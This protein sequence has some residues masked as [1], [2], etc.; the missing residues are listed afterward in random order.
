VL[1]PFV[2]VVVAFVAWQAVVALMLVLEVERD[3]EVVFENEQV[4]LVA[5]EEV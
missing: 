5:S 1:A 4:V 2:A 3:E